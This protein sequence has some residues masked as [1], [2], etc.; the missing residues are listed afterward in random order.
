MRAT[1]ESRNLL[2]FDLSGRVHATSAREVDGEP[3]EVYE[4]DSVRSGLVQNSGNELL[5]VLPVKPL[6][7]GSEHEIEIAH[8]GKVVVDAGHQVYFVSARGHLVSGARRP[9]RVV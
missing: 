8:E 6:E 1:D 3:A 4:R 5:L 9:V 7:P 2:A